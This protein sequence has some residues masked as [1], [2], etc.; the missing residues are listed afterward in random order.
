[1]A[2]MMNP[3]KGALLSSYHFNMPSKSPLPHPA[4]T[5]PTAHDANNDLIQHVDNM[6]ELTFWKTPCSNINW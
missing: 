1:M 2:E 3:E 4:M 6:K 5:Q